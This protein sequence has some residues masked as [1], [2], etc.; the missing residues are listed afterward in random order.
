MTRKLDQ[1]QARDEGVELVRDITD[2]VK[3]S[4]AGGYTRPP[5][6]SGIETPGILAAI[7]VLEGIREA[8]FDEVENR[9]LKAE[10][11]VA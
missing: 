6:Y 4:F 3:D 9:A 2:H 11:W 8:L 7:A 10:G 5:D 1:E